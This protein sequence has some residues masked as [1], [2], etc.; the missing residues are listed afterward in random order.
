[1]NAMQAVTLDLLTPMSVWVAWQTQFRKLGDPKPTKLPY[2]PGRNLAHAD[3]PE[4]WGTR[5]E[6]EFVESTLEKPFGTGGIGIE[7]HDLLDGRR[8]GGVDLDTCLD[9]ATGTIADWAREIVVALDSYTEVS[10]S[11]AGVKV[12]FTYDAGALDRLRAVMGGASWGK[13]FKRPSEEDH[14]PAIEVHLGNRYFAVTGDAIEDSPTEFRHVDANVLLD[15]L[16]NVGPRFSRSANENGTGDARKSG[17]QKRD[18]FGNDRSRSAQAFR[19]G[20]DLRRGGKTFEGM[21]AG[22]HADP[23]T[24]DWAREKGEP[25]GQREFRRIWEKAE[26][27]GRLIRVIA[28][29][30]H[31]TTTEAETALIEA[32][33]P[34]YQRG[35]A[36]AQ[37]VTREVPASRGRMTLA[38]G[39][40]ELNV[41]SMI[42][43]MC[44]TAEW[45]RFDGRDRNWVR[46]NPPAQIAQVLLSR[47]G[48]WRFPVVAGI[49][50]T[51]T[52]RPDGSLLTEPGYDAVTRLYHVEDPSLRLHPAVHRPTRATAEAALAALSGLLAEFPFVRT[53]L[54]DGT[55]LEVAK[56]VALSGCI[57]PVVRGAM[58]VA[59]LH[60]YNAHAPGS[61]K[62]YLVD[63]ASMI[64][65]GRPCPVIT[66]APDEAETEKRLVGLLLAGFP[67]VSI[68]NCNGELGGDLLCQAVERPLLRVRRLGTSDI[69]DLESTVTVFATGNNLRV[70][71]DMVR[72]S[73]IAEMDPQMERP[74][75]R[76]FRADPVLA[77]QADRG[78]FV[79]AA[80][81]IV[82]AYIAAGSPG[83]LPPVA[84]FDA[85]SDL[86]RSALVWLGCADPVLSMEKAREDDPELG[87]LREMIAAWSNAVG[88]DAVTC[89]AAI[90]TAASKG[91]KTNSDGDPDH[92]GGA[93][94]RYPD[95]AD[96]LTRIAG[97]RGNVDATRLGRW[98]LSREGRVVGR[99]RFARAGMTGGTVR[100]RLEHL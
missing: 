78:R 10:P 3:K 34:I 45:E 1:M 97:Y 26:A 57:T 38:A 19:K 56:A 84:S 64:A 27:K 35:E 41:Y 5:Q 79:S 18:M 77:I 72:R 25:N 22:L 9:P 44:A 71:G 6:A 73:L 94:A 2:G 98:L 89:R 40:G 39:L 91:P 48:R 14:P 82:R 50:T 68:D 92:Y 100:W 8:I 51:P 16:T 15:L 11:G 90:D 83:K 54:G 30:L 13:E 85:W 63:V 80:L 29:E 60:A 43:Q 36:L 81:I 93:E 58:P 59:P 99:K 52:L 12:F 53:Q 86:V 49:T 75:L 65:T 28:G 7:F 69:T 76:T 61:G 66:A 95:F 32:G 55:E 67:I 33:L 23:D 20:R 46:I 74:E 88:T 87:E 31:N 70:R 24:A 21:V 62:S 4:T 42:D 96:L 37:P 47:N 17:G